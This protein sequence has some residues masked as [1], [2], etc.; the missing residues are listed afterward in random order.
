[1]RN[2]DLYHYEGLNELAFNF[3]EMSKKDL[4]QAGAQRAAELMAQ[5]EHNEYQALAAGERLKTFAESF[6]KQLRK[7]IHALPEKNYKAYGVEFSTM[8]TGDRYDYAADPIYA[9]IA[10]QLKERED[11]LKLALKSANPIYD[12]E[13]I[14]VPK[15]PVKTFGSE[16]IKLKF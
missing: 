2:E 15:V 13:G 5:G 9:D 3:P 4:E 12:H 16:V 1:M 14:E 11:L 7:D 8:N 10:R 6:C